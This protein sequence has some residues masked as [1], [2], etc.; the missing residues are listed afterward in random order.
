MMDKLVARLSDWFGQE[1]S[2]NASKTAVDIVRD[3]KMELV[4]IV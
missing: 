2:R 1:I 4:F 3:K